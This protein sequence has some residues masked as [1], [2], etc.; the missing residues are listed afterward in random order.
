MGY[1]ENKNYLLTIIGDKL[2]FIIVW[3]Y[4]KD[5]QFTMR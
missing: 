2:R 3:E 4:F 5:N 1:G